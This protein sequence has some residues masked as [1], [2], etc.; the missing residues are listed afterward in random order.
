MSRRKVGKNVPERV[1]FIIDS[2]EQYLAHAKKRLIRHSR[3]SWIVHWNYVALDTIQ[4]AMLIDMVKEHK[5]TR[6]QVNTGDG[7]THVSLFVSKK[8]YGTAVT[9]PVPE[10]QHS[11]E[12]FAEII[13]MLTPEQLQELGL[14]I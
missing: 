11:A 13:G 7:P 2:L 9:E 5:M 4:I 6:I 14:D 10:P 1:R 3:L 12:T 8:E